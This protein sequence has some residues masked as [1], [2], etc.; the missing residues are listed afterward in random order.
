MQSFSFYNRISTCYI[1]FVTNYYYRL[2]AHLNALSASQPSILPSTASRHRSC[3]LQ[4]RSCL[5]SRY[6]QVICS[7][8]TY[9][10]KM[11]EILNKPSPIIIF[12]SFTFLFIYNVRRNT[13][14]FF[15][16]SSGKVF[17]S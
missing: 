8:F 16:A 17:F 4:T 14:I 9:M 6:V 13:K 11:F 12:F 1:I 2:S 15:F 5:S 10:L 3:R 7:L